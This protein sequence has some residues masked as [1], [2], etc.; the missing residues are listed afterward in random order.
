MKIRLMI[1]L[2][3]CMTMSAYAQDY[4]CATDEHLEQYLSASP[5]NRAAY[6]AE[7]QEFSEYVANRAASRG[8]PDYIIPVVV[9]VL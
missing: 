6:N 5:E 4:G 2:L 3:G 1:A 7:R 8:E 9:H